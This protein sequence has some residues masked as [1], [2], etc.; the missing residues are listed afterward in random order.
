MKYY[1][2]TGK[3]DQK[4]PYDPQLARERAASHAANFTFNREQQIAWLSSKMDR[5]PLIV[6]PYDAE[7]FGHWW[8]EGPQWLD[9][10]IRKVAYDQQVF[11]LLTP[12]DY[13]DRYPTNQ[14]ATPTASSWG[15]KGHNEVWLSEEN[16]WLY[17]HVHKAADRMSELAMKS[18]E[19]N[20]LQRR[21]L[22]QAARELL[23]AQSSTGPSSCNRRPR[24]TTPRNAP[25]NICSGLSRLYD[26]LCTNQINE[27]WLG[28]IEARD[29]IFPTLDYRVYR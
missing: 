17:R 5:L 2:I 21:S 1:R 3:T 29:N 14:V 10:V 23:L 4:M 20:E 16:D 12:S 24:N 7:L 25:P 9:S 13:L 6:A 19:A 27:Q 15:Y 8:F 18:P 11:Q 22:N 26:A 28:E